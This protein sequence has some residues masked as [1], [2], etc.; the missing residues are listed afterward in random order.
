MLPRL[1]LALTFA[2]LAI[3]SS[4]VEVNYTSNGEFFE[5]IVG[6]KTVRTLSGTS[7]TKADEKLSSATCTVTVDAPTFLLE[8][9]FLQETSFG[10]IDLKTN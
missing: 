2:P 8:L 1:S 9:E 3:S 5:H 10:E 4:A 6:T 7:F